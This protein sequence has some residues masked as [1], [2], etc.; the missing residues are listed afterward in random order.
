MKKF[1]LLPFS[2]GE[3]NYD[4]VLETN[5]R[6]A[7]NNNNVGGEE[8]HC[9]VTPWPL[10]GVQLV[11]VVH[12][13]KQI[14]KIIVMSNLFSSAGHIESANHFI[15]SS[16]YCLIF[17]YKRLMILELYMYIDLYEYSYGES[18]LIS[19]QRLY[20][21]YHIYRVLTQYAGPCEYQN[22]LYN[23]IL[24]YIN[25][26]YMIPQVKGDSPVCI[27]VCNFKIDLEA[28]EFLQTSHL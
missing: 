26:T 6:G 28:Y 22:F 23:G 15:Q 8:V 5:C 24:S 10:M 12:E 3:S 7:K 20:Y 9:L 14:T 18:I 17:Q 11:C 21:I 4:W 2:L 16:Q 25:H 27:L 13:Y 1:E 19:Q